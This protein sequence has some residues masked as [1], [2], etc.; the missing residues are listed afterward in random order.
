VFLD[1]D[2]LWIYVALINYIAIQ[3]LVY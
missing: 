2:D 3:G 1:S